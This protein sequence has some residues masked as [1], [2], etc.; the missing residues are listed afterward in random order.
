MSKQATLLALL[1]YALMP[2]VVN[3][4]SA[5]NYA[6]P[7]HPNET[8]APKVVFIGD[9]VTAQWASAFAANPN[10]I[11]QGNPQGICCFDTPVM[12]MAP[13]IALH[14]AAVH[15]M[16]G[17]SDAAAVHS[18]DYNDYIT[19]VVNEISG[20]VQQ[21]KAANIKVILGIEP[22]VLTGGQSPPLVNAVIAGY[23]A[24]NNIPVI[25]YGDALCTCV[26][27]V[28]SAPGFGSNP[29]TTGDSSY[30][31][32]NLYG[33]GQY[34]EA[35]PAGTFL[36]FPFPE[37]IVTPTGYS[38][39]TTLAESVI[40]TM[41]LKLETGWLSDVGKADLN[42]DYEGPTLVNVNTVSPQAVLQ[43]IP[44]G[45]YSDG[46]QHAVINTTFQGS[47]GTWT[48]SNPLVMYVSQT[49]VAWALSA[50]TTTIKYTPPN[51]AP[52]APWVMYVE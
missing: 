31:V 6:R 50:G 7:P 20:L 9:Y 24:V 8:F 28:G 44:I 3:A 27:S 46:S 34:F 45:L 35:A 22:Y 42:T 2:L 11:N 48:S 39:M 52:F 29:A 17:Q 26:G 47:S 49:G 37:E 4:Q 21:A 41:N 36:D 13:V 51:G 14:P 12:N 15:I 40:N 10:W 32:F 18:D 43:F 16:I 25:N 5:P 1:F 19:G 23:G 33:G 38:L 30:D